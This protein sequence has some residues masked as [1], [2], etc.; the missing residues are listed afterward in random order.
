[1]L[2]LTA[3][4]FIVDDHLEDQSRASFAG[5]FRK[6]YRT[7]KF[8]INSASSKLELGTLSAIRNRSALCPFC[9]LVV[10]SVETHP[11]RRNAID[12]DANAVCFASWEIDGREV[13]QDSISGTVKTRAR[14]RR[15]CLDW[16]GN[17]IQNSYIVLLAPTSWGSRGL[18]FGRHVSS[19][20]ESPAMVRR[21]LE[22]CHNSHGEKCKIR[23]GV[24]FERMRSKSFFGVIDVDLMCLRSLQLGERYVALSYTWG[25]GILFRSV[26]KNF[27]NLHVKGGIQNVLNRLPRV[28]RDAIYLVQAIGERYLWVDSLCII[29]DSQSSWDLNASLMD[30]VYGGAHLTICAADGE[31]AEA[32]LKGINGSERIFTQHIEEYDPGY[33]PSIDLMVSHLAETYIKQSV[34]NTR[35][36]TFQERMLSKRCL[37]FVDGRIYFQC[38]TTTMCEDTVSDHPNAGWSMELVQA[39]NQKLSDLH[40]RPIQVYATSV[41]LYTSR[42][43]RFEKDILSAFCG[44][45]SFIGNTLNA[46]LIYGLPNSHF[47]WALLWETYETDPKN[48]IRHRDIT[49]FP[50]WAWCG[51]MGGRMAYKSSMISG[52]L[53]NLHEWLMEH[54]WIV[55]YIRDGYGSL[56]LAWNDTR[57]PSNTGSVRRRWHG[58]SCEKSDRTSSGQTWDPYGRMIPDSTRHLTR[59]TFYLTL[60]P[61]Y[62]YSVNIEEGASGPY[63]RFPDL[64]YLQFWTWSAYLRLT[65]EDAITTSKFRKLRRYGISDHKGD[66]CGTIILDPG[67]LRY[68]SAGV[69]YEFL[70]IS[71]AK[72]FSQEEYTGWTYYIPK[73]REQ[74]EWDLYYVLLIEVNEMK[75]SRRLGLGK[76]YKEAFEN[77]CEPGKTWKEVILG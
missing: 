46:S 25:D 45:G 49:K 63:V 62:P 47:D 10:Q 48:T 20:A 60:M 22:I 68:H 32:G 65:F 55:W 51:W 70:A 52:T 36:W 50:S 56:R 75:V 13:V 53:I 58:Y 42:Q 69:N 23:R 77:S 33:A 9:R 57:H 31:N 21:W 3:E 17:E 27:P 43:L 35:A 30:I 16:P 66:W 64:P 34:W 59:S 12:L 18:F 72:D 4:K 5:S 8:G 1:M 19:A 15:I 2:E 24:E 26:V 44:I 41:E 11:N 71:E 37:I 40:Y 61:E 6:G 38:H 73:E 29:Q 54:T 67:H 14:T 76:V 7:G 28:I 74:S 39:P